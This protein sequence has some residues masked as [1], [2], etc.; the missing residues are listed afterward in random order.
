MS[1]N[2]SRHFDDFFNNKNENVNPTALALPNTDNNAS[3]DNV[4]EISQ[5]FGQLMSPFKEMDNFFGNSKINSMLSPFDTENMEKRMQKM[6]D[7]SF[8]TNNGN[9]PNSYSYCHS[10]ITKFDDKGQKYQKTHSITKGPN[11]IK[12]EKKT[13]DDRDQELKQMSLGQHIK[14]RGVEVEK[15]RKGAT[16]PITTKR[17]IY[18][19]EE[20]QVEDF[21]KDW[22]KAVGASSG[23]LNIGMGGSRERQNVERSLRNRALKY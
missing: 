10:S 23:L 16:N 1:R 11:G 6:M 12:Q 3:N 15:T 5:A 2:N 14:N 21:H 7:D 13:L 8:N 20:N 22:E 9:N 4:Q 17:N 19:M 18:G